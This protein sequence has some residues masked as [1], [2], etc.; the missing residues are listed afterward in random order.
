MQ[1]TKKY[2]VT[3][4]VECPHFFSHPQEPTC[5]LLEVEPYAGMLSWSEA[6]HTIHKR[7]PLRNRS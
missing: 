6:R 2:S 5:E 1:V 4:C 3:K 7:C